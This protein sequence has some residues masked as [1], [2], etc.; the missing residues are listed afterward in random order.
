MTHKRISGVFPYETLVFVK[1]MGLPAT[2]VRAKLTPQALNLIAQ[3]PKYVFNDMRKE[4]LMIPAEEHLLHA[5]DRY[6]NKLGIYINP[7]VWMSTT[8][9]I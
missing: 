7:D 2:K 8:K 4:V 9:G 5:L 6:K 3:N 1:A